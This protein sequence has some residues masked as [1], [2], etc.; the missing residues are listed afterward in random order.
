MVATQARQQLS[1]LQEDARYLARSNI[2]YQPPQCTGLREER[3]EMKMRVV[4]MVSQRQRAAVKGF[5]LV[6]FLVPPSLQATQ[7]KVTEMCSIHREK[8]MEREAESFARKEVWI[9]ATI[10]RE[11][12][13]HP[14][15]ISSSLEETVC[16]KVVAEWNENTKKEKQ[17]TGKGPENP[18]R[19]QPGR[20]ERVPHRLGIK[21]VGSR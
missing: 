4:K 16:R 11:D 17:Q 9:Q 2:K 1:F 12:P 5:Q 15:D 3:K 6:L 14:F 18:R 10:R 19:K 7:V 8:E 20:R 21:V 13:V